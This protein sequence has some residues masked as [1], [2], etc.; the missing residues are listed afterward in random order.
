MFT[1]F[2]AK[3]TPPVVWAEYQFVFWHWI[4]TYWA[5]TLYPGPLFTSKH[6]KSTYFMM[7]N[8]LGCW[9]PDLVELD[10]TLFGTPSPDFFSGKCAQMGYLANYCSILPHFCCNDNLYWN[11]DYSYTTDTNRVG[12]R[13]DMKDWWK[14][15]LTPRAIRRVPRTG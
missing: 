15:G 11:V 9:K 6:D 12:W 7:M 1:K 13:W 2:G 4:F 10:S 5:T 8:C 14:L 3:R